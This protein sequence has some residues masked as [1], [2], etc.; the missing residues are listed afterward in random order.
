[1][2]VVRRATVAPQADERVS[3]WNTQ[4]HQLTYTNFAI[5]SDNWACKH[6]MVGGST[7][8]DRCWLVN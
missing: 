6:I 8:K 1:M 4:S 7:K 5:A 2:I 3:A